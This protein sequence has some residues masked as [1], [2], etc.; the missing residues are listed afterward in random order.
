MTKETDTIQRVLIM[1]DYVEFQSL[2][3]RPGDRV[4]AKPFLLCS[5]ICFW[6]RRSRDASR[7]QYSG[8]MLNLLNFAAL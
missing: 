2:S 1:C 4:C 8:I 6:P 3:K 7:T 5:V